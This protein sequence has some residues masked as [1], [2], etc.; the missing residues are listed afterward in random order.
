MANLRYA[1][2]PFAVAVPAGGVREWTASLSVP[3]DV[4]P[5]RERGGGRPDRGLM[6]A[7]VRVAVSRRPGDEY[8]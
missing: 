3:A 7:V 5:E 8:R 1:P 6:R 2:S 4:S